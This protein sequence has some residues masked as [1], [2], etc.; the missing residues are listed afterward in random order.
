MV[1]RPRLGVIRAVLCLILGIAWVYPGYAAS[2]VIT[3]VKVA[4]DLAKI[5]IKSQGDVGKHAAFVLNG[6]HRL[7][8][9][10]ADASAAHTRKRIKVDREPIREIRVGESPSRVRVVVDFGANP[11]PPFKIQRMSNSILVML[12]KPSISTS[13]TRS[14][15]ASPDRRSKSPLALR[16]ERASGN[17]CDSKMLVKRSGVKGNLVFVELVCPRDPRKKYRIVVDLDFDAVRVRNASVSDATG[18]VKR[19]DLVE[20]SLSQERD[21]ET[22]GTRAGPRRQGER[23]TKGSPRRPKYKWGL[24]SVKT[25]GPE[26]KEARRGG[27]FR[28]EEFKL[29]PRSEKG[30]S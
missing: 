25:R 18:N 9:D 26:G 24:P 28:L 19:F 17:T 11:V 3:G 4:P 12:G 5:V 21:G 10:V 14:A 30:A 2:G 20:A 22:V 1:R 23:L 16:T 15:N 13:A 8:V 27:P 7:V 29:Q 6:P